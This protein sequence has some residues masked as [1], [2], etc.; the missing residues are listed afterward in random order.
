L[1]VARGFVIPRGALDDYGVVLDPATLD[2]DKTATQE[3]RARRA[4]ELPL[5]DRGPGFAQAE[6]RWRAFRGAAS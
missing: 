5:I 1:D 3:A 2:V 6:E 4:R